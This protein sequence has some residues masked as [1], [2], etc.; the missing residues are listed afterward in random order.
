ME[1]EKQLGTLKEAPRTGQ[2]PGTAKV[3][4]CQW[5]QADPPRDPVCSPDMR[6]ERA[7]GARWGYRLSRQ[8]SQKNSRTDGREG[9][10]RA[11]VEPWTLQAGHSGTGGDEPRDV[12]P[13]EPGPS[14]ERKRKGYAPGGMRNR[15]EGTAGAVPGD[16]EG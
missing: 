15:A 10:A 9:S 5:R 7:A 16:D 2:N 6:K 3:R 11:Q 4:S 14:K 12:W 8:A 1:I 13:G